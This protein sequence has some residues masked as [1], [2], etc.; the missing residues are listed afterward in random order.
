MIDF[1]VD[2]FNRLYSTVSPLCAK[3]RFLSTPIENYAKLPAA[4]L[5][6]MDNTTDA[7]KQS[8]TPVENFARITYQFEAVA[9]GKSECRQIFSAAD[10]KMTALNFTRISGQ[11]V[12]YPDNTAIVRYVARYEALVDTEGNLYRTGR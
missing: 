11:Y 8:S 1:E 10:E 3:N 9:S 12:T 2:V 5:W 7:R 4:A 6:E